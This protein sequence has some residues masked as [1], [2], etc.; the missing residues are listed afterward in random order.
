MKKKYLAGLVAATA[1]VAVLGACPAAF[2]DTLGA[3]GTKA[4]KTFGVA[5]EHVL[6]AKSAT[7][8]TNKLEA[9]GAEATAS[10]KYMVYVP[11]GSYKISGVT[12][13][14]NVVLAAEKKSKITSSGSI[15]LY[16]S[17]YGGS[18][19]FS[20]SLRD[21]VRLGI[22]KFT[23][24]NGIVQKVSITG[25]SYSAIDPMSAG[26]SLTGAKK[27][28]G[29]KILNC[30]FK[31]CGRQGVTS[32]YGATIKLIKKCKFTTMGSAAVNLHYGNV[33]K[34]MNNKITGCKDH[35]ISTNTESNGKYH[36]K[37]GTISGNTITKI[38]THGIYV[39]DGC[40]IKKIEKN[41]I[42][43]CKNGG[44]DVNGSGAAAKV[45]ASNSIKNCKNGIYLGKGKITFTSS[46]M[47]FS[48]NKTN[49]YRKAGTVSGS[50]YLRG[51]DKIYL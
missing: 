16:G 41:K 44:I 2:A 46:K 40:S 15:G 20:K 50:T 30:T 8:I 27:C 25:T 6:T 18:Y 32:W 5:S 42:S 43:N 7:Q 49:F 45:G 28:K 4:A 26:G 10:D 36:C 22:V 24:K 12:V 14:A 33:K 3:Y 34:V 38:S 48:G 21:G 37:I 31:N 9:A 47:S 19:T 23:K 51:F 17:M 1:A 39:E 29:A 11:A 35:G 13:P